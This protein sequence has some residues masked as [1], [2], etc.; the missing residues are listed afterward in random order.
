M[1]I[2]RIAD[3]NIGIKNHSDFTKNYM[4]E[5]LSSS[6]D[7]DFAVTVTDEMLRE[8]K[9]ISVEEVPERYHEITAILRAIC[10]EILEKYN[11]FFFH[12]SCLEYKGEAY[13]FT[14]KSGTGK[15]T[16]AR[17]WREVLKDEVTMI[18]D[19]KPIVRLIND[20]FYIYGT[21][22]N[23]KHRLSNNIKAPIKAIF[24]LEQAKENSVSKLDTL[25]SITRLLSQTILPDSKDSMN[26]LIDML[27]NLVSITPV[28]EL[29]CNI[30][31]EAVHTALSSL[32]EN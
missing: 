21:P 11:G 13:I 27:E 8:E 19:D 22:W 5:Y 16:H 9:D 26:H 2:Y 7:V 24:Y 1:D 32:K 31:H 15:S 28:Y 25:S 10:Y 23:G 4:K 6:N 12:C 3:L 18:N 29:K 20:K 17:L 14:A 30:S